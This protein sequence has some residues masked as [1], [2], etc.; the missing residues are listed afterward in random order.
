MLSHFFFWLEYIQDMEGEDAVLANHMATWPSGLQLQGKRHLGHSP[1]AGH[2][3]YPALAFSGS[4]PA[5]GLRAV[6]GIE[7]DR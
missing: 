7:R 1:N 5:A 4:K 2:T 6:R 3:R